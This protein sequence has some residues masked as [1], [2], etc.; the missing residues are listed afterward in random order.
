[1]KCA[2]Q[3][4][5]MG[6]LPPESLAVFEKSTAADKNRKWFESSACFAAGTFVHTKAGLV[7]IEQIKVGDYVLSQH[8]SGTGSRD[9]KRVLRTI[10]RPPERV[11]EVKYFPDPSQPR[12]ARITCTINHPFWVIDLGW[13]HAED[14]YRTPKENWLKLSDGANVKA[15]GTANIYISKQPGVGWRSNSSDGDVE[16]YGAL[17]DFVNHRLVDAKVESLQVIQDHQV[18]YNDSRFGTFPEELYLHLP[19]Y[20]LEVEDFHTYYVGEHGV[21]VHNTNCSGLSFEEMGTP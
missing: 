1:M 18:P 3:E 19:V 20:N 4:W 6:V 7:P 15:F 17:W 16:A 10:A 11:I 8:D 2:S 13:T 5:E 12:V 21:W 14:L 9:Y